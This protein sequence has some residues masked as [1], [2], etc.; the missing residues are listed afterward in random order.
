MSDR[1]DVSRISAKLNPLDMSGA[2]VFHI[3]NWGR[4]SHP[5]RLTVIRQLAQSRGRDPRIARV[6][7]DAIRKSGA[8]PRQYKK[9]AAALLRWVQNPKN[10][11]Y[12]NEP[13]ERLQDPIYTVETAKSGDCDDLSALLCA[14]FESINLPWRLVLSGRQQATGQLVRHIEGQQIPP[15]VRWTH[16]YCMVGT[17]PFQ[18]TEWYFC[19]P[20]IEGVPLGWDIIAGDKSY[21]PELSA[22]YKGPA[23]IN[24]AA[25]KA[26]PWAGFF[27]RT[28]DNP[29]PALLEA[30]GAA[31]S[32]N[33][34]SALVG[35]VVTAEDMKPW[36]RQFAMSVL[37][38]A[39]VAI[40][41]Q[42]ALIYIRPLLP[43]PEKVAKAF[44]RKG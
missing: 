25:S 8:S 22:A 2:T 5:E 37:A 6:A 36:R 1:L 7:V 21:L 38:G 40:V 4:M 12:I 33:S 20:T 16:I 41:S 15:H 34:I 3:A 24:E 19:E 30:W 11:Y 27:Q 32:N 17:P 26:P 42:I 43:S 44:G 10:V 18:P 14:L 29:S 28:I 39:T 35:G 9:Q 31:G 13:G 23:R